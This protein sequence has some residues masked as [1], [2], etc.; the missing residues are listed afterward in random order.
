MMLVEAMSCG[1][2]VITSNIT[3]MPEVVGDAGILVDPF[4]IEEI[5][6]AMTTI[7]SDQNLR[8]ELSKKSIEQAKNFSWEKT[9]NLLWQSILKT[10]DA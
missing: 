5:S 3:S 6:E 4:K 8:T 10:I 9:G 1:V 2:P 7:V